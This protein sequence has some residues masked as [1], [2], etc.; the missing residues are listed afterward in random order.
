MIETKQKKK[1]VVSTPTRKVKDKE[2]EKEI[3]LINNGE[4]FI[5]TID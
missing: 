2:I 3:M 1:K 5:G 4:P